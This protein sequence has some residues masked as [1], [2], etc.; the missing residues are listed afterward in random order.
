MDNNQQQP[1][2]NRW[3]WL[4]QHMPGIARLIADKRRELGGA[5]VGE[6][7]KRGVLQ[8]EPGW[9]FASEGSLHVGTLWPDAMQALI[10]LRQAA[11]AV[12]PGSP[13]GAPLLILKPAEVTHAK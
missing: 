2:N 1:V 11:E 8:Q 7:W 13:S 12:A 5:Y 3:N 6:C 9:F 10:D 4:P